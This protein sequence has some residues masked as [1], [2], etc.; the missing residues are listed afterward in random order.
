MDW[1]VLLIGGHSGTG[2]TVV[3]RHLTQHFGVGLAEVDDFRLVLER[4]STPSQLPALHKM[5]T[6][7]SEDKSPVERCATLITVGQTVSYALEIVVANHVAT[8][9]P[10]ILEGDGIIPSFAAQRVFANLDV[11]SA[12]RAVFIIEDNEERLFENAT[13]RGRGFT[14]LSLA[15]QQSQVHQSWLYG[16]WLKQEAI[17]HGVPVVSP[18]PWETLAERIIAYCV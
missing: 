13:T 11:E 18:L 9:T 7:E 5:T 15:R 12:V 16:Q 8:N 4:M 14:Q 1:K 17:Q 2:K 10:M 3:A 6:V